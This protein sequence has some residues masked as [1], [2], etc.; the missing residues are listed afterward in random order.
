[1]DNGPTGSTVPRRQLGR[2]LRDLRNQARMTVRAAARRLEWSEAKMWRIETGQTSLRSLDVEAMCKVYG[3]PGQLTEALMAL[4][5]ETKARGWWHAYGDVI[6]E[7]F[8]LFIGL[9]EAAS[10]IDW[11]ESELVPGLLQTEEYARTVIRAGKPDED[12]EE[13]ERRV[14][15]R[16][17]RQVLLT[18]V[19]EPLTFDA[20]INEAVLRRPI[21]GPS[22][23][24]G[25]L[26]RLLIV[27]E[28][29][30]VTIKVVPFSA[31]F[32]LGV[33][34]GSFG[35]LRFP[36]DGNGAETEPPT[37]YADGFTGDLYLDKPH[38][39]ERYDAAFKSIRAAALDEQASRHLI[40]EVAGSYGQD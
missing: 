9:E 1:M 35:V 20:V 13:V 26:E 18:R 17:A 27:S 37:V 21:G 7:G 5:K 19:T 10:R 12:D 15:L 22:V 2:N 34:S 36:L 24:S 3:A 23:M 11:Y 8:D 30:N 40:S 14:R 32:H 38:E 29:P 6:P 28:L 31:G 33:L 25:Q 16:T 4:A 39:V